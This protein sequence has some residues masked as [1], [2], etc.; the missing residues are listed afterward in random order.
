MWRNWRFVTV[1]SFFEMYKACS[2]K[3]IG[4]EHDAT[5]SKGI[6]NGE[7]GCSRN[8][9]FMSSFEGAMMKNLV[10]LYILE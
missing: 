8:C 4:F 9:K 10:E 6:G 1:I 2:K 3:M 5:E 7:S